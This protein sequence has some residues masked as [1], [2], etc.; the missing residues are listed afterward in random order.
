[1]HK[2][3]VI[4]LIHCVITACNNNNKQEI[5]KDNLTEDV[6]DT[7]ILQNNTIIKLE[8][9]NKT[10]SIGWQRF[11]LQEEWREDNLTQQPF[12]PAANFYK[13]YASALKWSFDSSKLL[14]L[15]SYS[16]ILTTNEKGETMLE[17]GGEPDTEVAL[18]VPQQ[19]IR[20]RLLFM[21][22][23]GNIFNG[24]WISDNEVAILGRVD[25]IGNG[26]YDT[27]LWIVNIE[28]STFKK[29]WLK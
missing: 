28:G 22:P 2:L 10:S 15:G 8:A 24:G 21:G 9:L 29:F 5:I 19:K 20:K 3:I 26:Q 12:D 6:T 25:E 4:I 13:N 18:I 16:S 17:P 27:L 14:D 11:Q 23:A 1:M 7:D